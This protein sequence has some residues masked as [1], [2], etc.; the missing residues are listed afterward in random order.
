MNHWEE[1]WKRKEPWARLTEKEKQHQLK[2][3]EERAEMDLKSIQ[4]VTIVFHKKLWH[5]DRFSAVGLEFSIAMSREEIMERLHNAFPEV[6]VI[7]E[8]GHQQ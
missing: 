4:F 2:S 8:E 3:K 5:L 6:E 7:L 1:P